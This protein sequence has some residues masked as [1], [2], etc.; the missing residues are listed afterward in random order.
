M[1]HE[2]IVQAFGVEQHFHGVEA[3]AATASV[4]LRA[5]RAA[6]K[7]VKDVLELLFGEWCAD[8]FDGQF[9]LVAGNCYHAPGVAM[10][11]RV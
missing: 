11:H 3:D 9:V 6:I 2:L 1:R 10:A 4:L 5:A 7:R 8:V